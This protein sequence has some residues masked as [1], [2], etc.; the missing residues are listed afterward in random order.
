MIE[1]LM[2]STV[3]PPSVKLDKTYKVTK[4][5]RVQN[6][7]L[8]AHYQLRKREIQKANENRLVPLSNVPTKCLDADSNEFY[9]FHGL[10]GKIVNIITES[11]FDERVSS[12]QGLFGG[13]IYFA[14][15]SSKSDGY[16]HTENCG[17]VGAVYSSKSSQCTCADAKERAMLVCR[18]LVGSP[19]IKLLPLDSKNPLRRPPE[20]DDA[21]GGHFDSVVGEARHHNPS[22]A[23]S[24]REIIVYDRKQV[25]PEY[26][27]FYS[28]V[29]TT[30]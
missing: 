6:P 16:S 28:R 23:L 19:C 14:E 26:L 11:G 3:N 1:K 13:G 24:F 29:V 12:L 27:V 22:A 9:L 4:M 30:K 18:V 21:G 8:W 17:Q 20:R 5:Y 7:D 2:V 10:N 15:N 25:Y